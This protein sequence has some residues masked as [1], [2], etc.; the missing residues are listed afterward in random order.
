MQDRNRDRKLAQMKQRL[1]IL[2]SQGSVEIR[3]DTE[4]EMAAII[5]KYHPEIES[6]PMSDVRRIFW[7]QQVIG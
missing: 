5:Q 6:L 4:E 3:S 2:T 1:D 7:N